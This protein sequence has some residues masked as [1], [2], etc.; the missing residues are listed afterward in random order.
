MAASGVLIL[1]G[2]VAD[3][4]AAKSLLP[5][6]RVMVP[7]SAFSFL[8]VGTAL[9]VAGVSR[10]PRWVRACV[11]LGLA[12]VGAA[13]PALT[14]VEYT[15]GI[16]T[17]LE[18]WLGFTFDDQ[19]PYAGRMSPMTALNLS[20]LCG[21]VALTTLPG[22][23]VL[24]A[25]AVA[26]GTTLLTSWL[27]LVA[28]SLD[29]ERLINRPQFPGMAVTTIVLLALSSAATLGLITTR[30]PPARA[31]LRW[32][33]WTLVAAFAAPPLL[34]LGRVQIEAH[35]WAEPQL[36]T[37]AF[38]LGFAVLVAIGVW[39]YA[40]RVSHLVAEREQAFAE[41]EDRV[42]ERT[43]ALASS[44]DEL[45]RREDE[46]KDAD[47]RKD[48]FLATLAHE[49]RNPLAPIRNAAFI[50][51]SGKASP[52]QQQTAI[53]IVDRQAS[54]MQR[55]IDDLLDVSRITAGKLRI[56]TATID[57]KEII[58]QAVA[59]VQPD[60]EAAGHRLTVSLPEQPLPVDGDAARL[61]QAF[62]NLMHNA[63]KF[64]D[65]GGAIA[66]EARCT[67]DHAVAVTVRDTGIGIPV[68]FLPRLFEK[69]SQVSS[70]QD[71]SQ[72]GLGLGLSLVHG[73]VT[74]HGGSVAA[75]SDGLG[76]GSAFLV[77]LPLS[78][79]EATTPDSPATASDAS[80]GVAKRVLVVD[81]NEDSAVSLAALLR[82]DGHL[83][84]MA[85]DGQTALAAVERFRPEVM[86]LDL[87]MPH[88]DGFEVCRQVRRS[89][90]G[91]S[92]LLIAQTGW[93]Q[94]RDRRR[95]REAGFDWHLTKPVDHLELQRL[96]AQPSRP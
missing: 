4:T 24:H 83:V 16:R 69:F 78:R 22:R 80:P 88:L 93:G 54:V 19:L 60:V 46:L 67:P 56:Q 38:A 26:A 73:I 6:W 95:T 70:T 49:L 31:R 29:T 34:R 25:A 15:T 64:T 11:V 41:L 14:A 76:K 21:A 48:E 18:T 75:E 92:I 8:C 12:V 94:E 10:W 96:L 77:R 55:L 89:P 40:V 23:A 32:P 35:G 51:Q 84:A 20:V 27:G 43:R 85:H 17:G 9:A 5:G 42:S 71:R 62:A 36:L 79:A 37:A 61:S 52:P 81:D 59:T 44:N 1:L 53:A 86:L 47:R 39:R 50:L 30:L 72:G 3:L 2:W 58:G 74:L 68:A 13:L 91:R 33:V 7:S 90:W 45:R 28:L 63:C 66:V 87:G 65:A 82:L 57:L